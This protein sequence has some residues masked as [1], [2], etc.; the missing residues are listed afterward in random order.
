MVFLLRCAR[1]S[2]TIIETLGAEKL[3]LRYWPISL[4]GQGPLSA[5]N[6]SFWLHSMQTAT[7]LFLKSLSL[8]IFS[9][10]VPLSSTQ[11]SFDWDP[12]SLLPFPHKTHDTTHMEKKLSALPH[13]FP[14]FL[15]FLGQFFF[16]LSHPSVVHSVF[17][18]TFG[19]LQFPVLFWRLKL[20]F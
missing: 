9:L 3:L 20:L 7:E 16:T 17:L 18:G 6:H 4:R 1:C 14:R 15:T 12:Q 8:P 19:N 5:E 2:G 10:Q 13:R 11:L